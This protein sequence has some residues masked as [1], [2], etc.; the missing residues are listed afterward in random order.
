MRVLVHDTKNSISLVNH[1]GGDTVELASFM[2]DQSGKDWSKVGFGQYLV[3]MSGMD[4]I[5]K[6]GFRSAPRYVSISDWLAEVAF[7][8]A[9]AVVTR[10]DL[11][12]WA[13]NKDGGAHVDAS[14]PEPYRA[15]QTAWIAIPEGEAGEPLPVQDAGLRT[16]A[17]ELLASPLLW[18]L[19]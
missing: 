2:T 6:T 8:H 10:R 9:S 5:P 14:L 18:A 3:S 7:I 15:L 11:M 17:A 12:L 4:V 13:S 16:M 19:S 1:L